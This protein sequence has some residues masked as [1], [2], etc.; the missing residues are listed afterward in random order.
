MRRTKTTTIAMT[1]R[2]PKVGRYLITETN[3][4]WTEEFA[5]SQDEYDALVVALENYRSDL[6]C[7]RKSANGERRK[8]AVL[9]IDIDASVEAREPA[10]ADALTARVRNILAERMERFTLS[11][12][13][14][15]AC[16][17]EAVENEHGCTTPAEQFITTLAYYHARGGLTPANAAAHLEVFRRD[18]YEAVTIHARFA[19]RYGQLDGGDMVKAG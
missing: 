12:L 11:D 7:A 16:C 10:E 18:F 14:D 5:V 6:E 2:V 8:R 9:G 1:P 4:Q 3:G 17:M 15:L 13:Q 19:E